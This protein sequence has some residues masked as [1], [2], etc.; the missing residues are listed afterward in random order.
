[1]K[2]I[3][4]IL[5]SLIIVALIVYISLNIKCSKVEEQQSKPIASTQKKK[6]ETKDKIA[7]LIKKITNEKMM[8]QYIKMSMHT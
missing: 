4:L 5:M 6:T 7:L 8:I 2:N 1:M 3:L